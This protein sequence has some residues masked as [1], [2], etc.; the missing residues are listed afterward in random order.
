MRGIVDLQD[1]S[2]NSIS[3]YCNTNENTIYNK[4]TTNI[5]EKQCNDETIVEMIDMLQQHDKKADNNI[6]GKKSI[7]VK[8]LV[9]LWKKL[10][11]DNN[12]L[13]RTINIEGHTV[14]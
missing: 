7:S 11:I 10:N 1:V 5:R 3:T 6:I 9:R 12:L 13:C 2:I 8:K 14:R 4:P